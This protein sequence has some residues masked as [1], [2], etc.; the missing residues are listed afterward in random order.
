MSFS[1]PELDAEGL[2]SEA[3][4]HGYDG[5]ELRVAANHKHSAETDSD[6]AARRAIRSK[7]EKGGV[8]ICCIA[9]S[10][11]YA[12]P[13]T[14]EDNVRETLRSI[15]LASDLGAP[16]IRVFGGGLGKGLSRAD[17]IELVA[18]SL[19]AADPRAEE[20]GVTVCME[21]HDDWC[22]PANIAAVLKKV[23][24]PSIA[25]NWDYNA[26]GTHQARNHG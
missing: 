14:A 7:F 26:P 11:R 22:D 12:D 9:T 18:K 6:A 15:D 24:H 5:V 3:A 1:C 17:A 20:R 8:A 19:A 2:A 25:A 23:N 16:V 10:C 21:T 4:R 13:A